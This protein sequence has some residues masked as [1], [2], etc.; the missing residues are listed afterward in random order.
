MRGFGCQGNYLALLNNGMIEADASSAVILI[1][2]NSPIIPQSEPR[3][4][5]QAILCRVKII[6]LVN[7]GSIAS[8]L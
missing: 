1:D 8:A 6:K 5:F 2:E 4:F 3:Q 7:L